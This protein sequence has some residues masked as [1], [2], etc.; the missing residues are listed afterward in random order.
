M[1][2]WKWSGKFHFLVW[3]CTNN[4]NHTYYNNKIKCSQIQSIV[5]AIFNSKNNIISYQ[6][7][8]GLK[9]IWFIVYEFWKFYNSVYLRAT[10]FWIFGHFFSCSMLLTGVKNWLFFNSF[11]I[12]FC[13]QQGC[14]PVGCALPTCCPY[15]PAC[16]VQGV[17]APGGGSARG[18]GVCPGGICLEGVCLG[19][20]VCPE[21]CVSQHALRQTLPLWTEWQTGVKI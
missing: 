17:S 21:G 9:L 1:P 2:F 18:D 6:L 15:L 11:D 16:T 12:I 20:G 7:H 10:L 13:P 4:W 5:H 3:F 14:I 8:E 19:G